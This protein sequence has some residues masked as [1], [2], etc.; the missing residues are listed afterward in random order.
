VEGI[1]QV[2]QAEENASWLDQGLNAH[3]VFQ[4]AGDGDVAGAVDA[5]DLYIVMTIQFGHG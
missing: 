3:Q 4:A 5:G 2:K 1:V